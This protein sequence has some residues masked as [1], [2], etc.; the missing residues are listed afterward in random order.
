MVFF[1]DP[2]VNRLE[3]LERLDP[4]EPIKAKEQRL[5]L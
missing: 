2:Q 5:C 3:R 1:V 4:L